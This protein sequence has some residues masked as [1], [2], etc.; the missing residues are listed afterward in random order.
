MRLVRYFGLGLLAFL[1]TAATLWDLSR[2]A[3]DDDLKPEAPSVPV[4]EVL[5]KYL[6]AVAAKDLKAMS[7]LADVPWLDRDRQVV[8]ERSELDKALQLVA[9]QLPKGGRQRKVETFPYK[10]MRDR[11]KGEAVRKVLDEVLG[12]DGWLVLVEEN[13][14]PM[15]M[16]TILI[17]AKGGK[18]AVVAGPL[19][20][21]QVTLQ[22]RIPEAAERLFDK[23][24]TFELFSLNPEPKR[25]KDGDVVD[26]KEGF[27]G[28]QVLGKTEVK[29]EAERKRLADALRLG[30]E[31]NFG[32]AAGCFNP[33]HGLRLKGGG[34]SVD[35]VI[36]FECLQV[37]VFVDGETSQG[38]LTSGDPQKEFDAALKA[39]GIN[40]PKRAKK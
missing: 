10:K 35:L 21:N 12:E 13:G 23:A 36:C 27:H 40:L 4:K 29:K 8:R 26:E 1:L 37:Q 15:S 32:I 14:Y 19:K 16:R 25:G 28:W 38:F 5:D 2:L 30:A 24:E 7:A 17:R 3:A 20:E 6:K 18:V 31:D 33:R 11:I 39:A 34:K 22:N 9:T